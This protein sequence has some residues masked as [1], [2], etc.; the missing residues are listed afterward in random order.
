MDRRTFIQESTMMAIGVSAFGKIGWSHDRYIGNNVTTTDIL[1]PF[2]RPGAPLRT[3][4]NPQGYTGKLLHLRG[5]IFKTDGVSPLKNCTIEIW[6]CDEN[7]NYD[8]TSDEFKYR[9]RQHATSDG[10][11][12]FITARPVAYPANE[13]ANIWRPAHI[14]LVISGEDQQDLITQ[15]Y[16]TGDPYLDTDSASSSPQA[17]SRILTINKNQKGEEELLF[18][19]VMQEEFKVDDIVFAKISGIYAMSDKSLMEF[20]RNGDLLFLK[21]NGQIREALSY[22]GNNEFVSGGMG[23]TTAKF[24]LLESNEVRVKVNFFRQAYNKDVPLEGIKSFK[25]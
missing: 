9:G 17:K 19:V 7:R 10:K 8:N 3:N 24:E 15:I 22:Q 14:H 21:W 12:H 4:I 18:D 6:Q 1:G 16:L 23:K 5:T 20:Y 13:S 11:Y 2:Y 25:Y